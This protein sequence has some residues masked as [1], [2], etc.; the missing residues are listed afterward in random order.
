[1]IIGL[2]CIAGM[3]FLYK[4]YASGKERT[5]LVA[6]FSEF[7]LK[8][9]E[10]MIESIGTYRGKF[11]E[12]DEQKGELIK[13]ASM[14]GITSKYEMTGEYEDDRTEVSLVKEGK[15]SHTSLQFVTIS[16]KITQETGETFTEEISNFD[17]PT[18]EPQQYLVIQILME[19]DLDSALPFKEK[20]D[21]IMKQY[22]DNGNTTI[23]LKGSYQG[24]LDL[25]QRNQI[26]DRLLETMRAVVVS[27]HRDMQLYTIYGYTDFI[28]ESKKM[29]DGKINLNI[30]INYDEEQDKTFLYF[31]SPV[32]GFA[33]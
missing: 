28:K 2:W 14:L 8:N 7:E 31:A 12:R 33:Y 21:K 3:Q 13:I 17:L 20:T 23:N 18:S 4:Q 11:L 16:P 1:M 24:K 25:E 30:A 10:S 29:K 26:S 9:Q 27:Q 15:R 6:A 19:E 22:S 5:D 32:V